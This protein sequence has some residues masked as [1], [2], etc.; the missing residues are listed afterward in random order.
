MDQSSDQLFKCPDCA[1]WVKIEAKVCRFCGRQIA[2][3]I[4]QHTLQKSRLAQEHLK[5]EEA[6]IARKAAEYKIKRDQS[7]QKLRAFLKTPGFIAFGGII[8]VGLLVFST[9]LGLNLS[10]ER[11]S[12]IEYKG[13]WVNRV[14]ECEQWIDLSDEYVDSYTVNES[15]SELKLTIYNWLDSNKF[16]F[17][18]GNGIT[19]DPPPHP[20]GSSYNLG[21]WLETNNDNSE[22]GRAAPVVDYGN[23]LVITDQSLV[24]DVNVYRITITKKY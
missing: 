17:C 19:V 15:N 4:K 18:V 14:K 22:R 11:Q 1:E 10:A 6:R 24:N 9:V 3:D 20:N 23:L 5:E 21:Y 7:R 13:D 2:R 8:L 12:L 16:L